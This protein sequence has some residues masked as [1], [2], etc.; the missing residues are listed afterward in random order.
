LYKT[1]WACP[2]RKSKDD[3]CSRCNSKEGCELQ[4]LKP[5][6]RA[7]FFVVVLERNSGSNKYLC[8][9]CGH[10][11]QGTPQRIIAHKLRIAG[12]GVAP[13][14]EAPSDRACTDLA[15]LDEEASSRTK[16]RKG[17]GA[18]GMPSFGAPGKRK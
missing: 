3:V 1:I 6:N 18:S 17:S 8:P 15:K 11:F 16:P 13:C 12:R 7:E 2:G 9:D 5:I 4:A 14:K 10:R